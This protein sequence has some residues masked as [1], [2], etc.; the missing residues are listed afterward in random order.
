MKLQLKKI[1]IYDDLSEET[2]CFTAELYADGKMVAKERTMAVVVVRMCTSPKDGTA[3]LRNRSFRL[4]RRIP[5]YTSS[6]GA[7]TS[8]TPWRDWW[9]ICSTSGWKR[10]RKEVSDES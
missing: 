7:N 6:I 1:K 4:P 2:I 3:T 8:R 10:K 9:T 5:L